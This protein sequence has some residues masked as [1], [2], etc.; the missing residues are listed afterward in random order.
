MKKTAAPVATTAEAFYEK[1]KTLRFR[2][3]NAWKY[4]LATW[5]YRVI[6]TREKIPV[7]QWKRLYSQSTEEIQE[8][9]EAQTVDAVRYIKILELI[10]WTQQVGRDT[11]T[12]IDSLLC[13]LVQARD[14][15]RL[16]CYLKPSSLSD[17][18]LQA[19]LTLLNT[20]SDTTAFIDNGLRFVEA[21][22]KTA[23]AIADV[24]GFP[25]YRLFVMPLPDVEALVTDFNAAAGEFIQKMSGGRA[26]CVRLITRP[27]KPLP[28]ANIEAVHD[29]AK[30][31]FDGA[32]SWD[33]LL[34]DAVRGYC[35]TYVTRTKKQQ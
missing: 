14:S 34:P 5:I 29:L 32:A 3:S 13:N 17:E 28:Q 31:C 22:N 11:A 35:D 4:P 10:R 23:E 12:F 9:V 26:G 24:L 27:T 33:M 19:S 30:L 16:L 21:F 1:Y 15:I 25:E 8:K 7:S 6:E 2:S 18:A 20:I